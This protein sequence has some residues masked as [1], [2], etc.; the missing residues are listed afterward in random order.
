[1]ISLLS[2][3]LTGSWVR[4]V[5]ITDRQKL[6]RHLM[7]KIYRYVNENRS[8]TFRNNSQNNIYYVN[9]RVGVGE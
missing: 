6:E 1:M 7:T 5:V 3:P 8:T 2:L 9:R 4:H